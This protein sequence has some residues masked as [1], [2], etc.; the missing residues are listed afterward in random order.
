MAYIQSPICWQRYLIMTCKA[1]L[2]QLTAAKAP[3]VELVSQLQTAAPT[4]LLD[5]GLLSM[6]WWLTAEEALQVLK[7]LFSPRA[8]TTG[9]PVTTKWCGP[10]AV[11]VRSLFKSTIQIR[12]ALPSFIRLAKPIRDACL[13]VSNICS[14]AQSWN[15]VHDE[16]FQR[17]VPKPH[18]NSPKRQIPQPEAYQGSH[19]YF[20]Q[21]QP[22]L[23]ST[24]SSHVN[25]SDKEHSKRNLYWLL[26]LELSRKTVKCRP[27]SMQVKFP[28][29][30]ESLMQMVSC[31]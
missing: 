24:A 25:V 15:L 26:I 16:V 31:S 29:M 2:P 4:T 3:A 27:K 7:C 12:S 20:S 19:N 18:R 21:W 28:I 10:A 22:E 6:L 14:N 1:P 30:P 5:A 9:S 13:T 17:Y 8:T 11:L 23:S